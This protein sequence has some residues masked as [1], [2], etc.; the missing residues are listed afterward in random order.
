MSE[1]IR[2]IVDKLNKEPYRKSFTIITFDS[3]DSLNLLQILN[4]VVSDIDKDQKMDLRD[5]PPEQTAIRLLSIIKLLGYK[6]QNDTGAGMNAFRQGLVSG[7]KLTIYP[8]LKWLLEKTDELKKRAYL[9]RF[10][11]KIEVPM[12][13]IQDPVVEET[14]QTYQNMLEHFKEI[15]KAVENEKSSKYNPEEVRNDIESMEA[16]KRQLERQLERLKRRMESFP[17]HQDMLESATNLRK[18]REKK[19]KLKEQKEDQKKQLYHS[20]QKWQRLERELDDIKATTNGLTA[21]L[22]LSKAEEDNQLQKML[23]D[24]NLPQKIKSKRDQCI[25]LER[26]LSEPV[27]SELD[28]DVIR[29][30]ID[31][32]NE[33]VHQLMAKKMADDE[34]GQENMSMFRSQASVIKHKRQTAGEEVQKLLEEVDE[35]QKELDEKQGQLEEMGGLTLVKEDEFKKY[36]EQLR[37]ISNSFKTKKKELSTLRAEYG[38]L[39]RTREILESRDT[40]AQELLEFAE[41]RKGISGYRDKQ[42]ELEEVS[43]LKG[44]MDERKGDTLQQMSVSIAKLKSIIED[45]KSVLAPLIKEV[46]PLRLQHQEMKQFHKEKKDNYDAA[47]ADYQSNRS[48]IEKRVQHLWGECVEEERKYH[49]LNCQ[50]ESIRLHDQRV[51]AEIKAMVSKDPNEKKKCMRDQ[52]TR[53]IHEQENMGRSLRDKQKAIKDTHEFALKQVKMWQDLEHLF[54]AKKE[55]F[56]V[57]EERKM[58]AKELEELS[59][60]VTNGHI[61]IMS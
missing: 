13:H 61:Q 20:Q 38:V 6:A 59:T 43:K 28:L 42:G 26:V 58:R 1:Q 33:E 11:V 52:L 7:D 31:E 17:H 22:V 49:L 10:L 45:K 18:E 14:Y 60:T 23:A 24:D 54:V 51:K 27:V 4:D 5:E 50:L 15:H 37:I 8:L 9:A 55:C 30:Q 29:Q 25:E 40:R 32:V 12:E 39:A 57:Q 2:Y 35:L 19:M 44:Q 21:E 41:K 56:K 16:E 3:L 53:K 36:V 34:S 47:V 48:H 46:R